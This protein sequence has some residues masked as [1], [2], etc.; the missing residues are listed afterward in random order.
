VTTTADKLD[1][2]DI[3]TNQHEQC[4]DVIGAGI[5]NDDSDH[6][7]HLDKLKALMRL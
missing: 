3:I 6:A 4:D 2:T 7:D 1:H 5:S